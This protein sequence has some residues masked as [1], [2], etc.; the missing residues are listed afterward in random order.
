MVARSS[1]FSFL[2]CF[3]VLLPINCCIRLAIS[4]PLIPRS[5]PHLFHRR[6]EL[7]N[8]LVRKFLSRLKTGGEDVIDANLE[9][10]SIVFHRSEN[11]E[12]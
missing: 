1:G 12:P 6:R 9:Q 11:I 3:T 10:Y 8:D 4:W 5:L 2:E 7:G